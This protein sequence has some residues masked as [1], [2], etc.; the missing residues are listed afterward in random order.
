MRCPIGFTVSLHAETMDWDRWTQDMDALQRLGGVTIRAGTSPWAV[1][2]DQLAHVRRC[3]EDAH[4]RGLTVMLT[5]SQLVGNHGST[6]EAVLD[7]ATPAL[8]AEAVE[9]VGVVSDAVGDLVTWWQV[10]NEHDARDWRDWSRALWDEAAVEA[11]ADPDE[12]V[13]IERARAHM[14]PAY[15]AT[16]RDVIAA[17]RDRIHRDYPDIIVLTATTGVGASTDVELIW[18]RFYDVVAPA[19]D[20]IGLNLYPIVWWAKYQEMPARLR[21][22][23]RRYDRPVLLTEIGLPSRSVE[24]DT[25]HGEWLAAQ[26]DRGTRSA[27]VHGLW[28]YQLRDAGPVTAPDYETNA[29]LRFGLLTRDDAHPAGGVEKSY[30]PAV[31]AMIRAVST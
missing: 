19:V 11:A 1:S 12:R 8:I 5:C 29:E 18:R 3:L 24:V 6:D 22:V 17:C 20:A 21:R 26:V 31:R 10:A 4:A 16:L 9:Y 27:D 23:A 2:D 7:A 14:T 25:E 13:A 15:L 28:L 30:A